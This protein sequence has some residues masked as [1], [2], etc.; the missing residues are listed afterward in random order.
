MMKKIGITFLFLL[1]CLG[2]SLVL[3][4][5][6]NVATEKIKAFYH[7][8]DPD[9]E[10]VFDPTPWSGGSHDRRLDEP[11]VGEKL[12]WFVDPFSGEDGSGKGFIDAVKKYG[13]Y[14]IFSVVFLF[15]YIRYKKKKRKDK[16]EVMPESDQARYAVNSV[17]LQE[18]ES[19]ILSE[20]N[21]NEIRQIL[22]E[23][24]SHLN[25]LNRKRTH[26]T[27]QE[28][29]KRIKSPTEIIPV[30]EKVRYGGKQFT[31]QELHLLKNFLR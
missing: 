15:W 30:Y 20:E 23:W 13:V 18:D 10:W 19:L 2:A 14:V 26:E 31:S 29:F 16:E 25:T 22:K 4:N 12:P 27:I 3:M 9:R 28:W 5:V 8:E 7:V 11:I 21:L 1:I 17:D 24:E 6:F